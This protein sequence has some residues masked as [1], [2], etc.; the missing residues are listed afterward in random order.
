MNLTHCCPLFRTRSGVRL[1]ALSALIFGVSL[2]ASAQSVT[3]YSQPSLEATPLTTIDSAMLADQG[4]PVLDPD[5]AAQ[6]WLFAEFASPRTV[7]V[8]NASIGKDL[9]PVEAAL[10][11]AEPNPN[12][13]VLGTYRS[14]DPI[15]IVDSGNWW[16]LRTEAP[17][18]VYFIL[19]A[20][21]TPVAI[22]SSPAISTPEPAAVETATA[23]PSPALADAPAPSAVEPVLT[24]IIDVPA[25]NSAAQSTTPA[26]TPG[27]D[28]PAIFE[29]TL[30]RVK[31]KWGIWR[32]RFP[33]AI[34]DD[35]GRRIA[36]VDVS[37]VIVPGSL[38][39][40][41]D[42]PVSIIGNRVFDAKSKQW[43][44]LAI[45]LRPQNF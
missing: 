37:Q 41:V 9:Q 26:T 42:Q 13:E 17:L 35:R 39:D 33:Y 8:P 18:P 31:A 21:A 4:Q 11:F 14:G 3:L 40:F 43:R 24:P 30:V 15:E 22:E 28:V 25:A 23:N 19:P 12:A 16:T 44:I 38:S 45:S 2:S 6:G 10:F 27:S 29:G 20:A 36:W 5:L 7:Y 34:E 32:P 1:S